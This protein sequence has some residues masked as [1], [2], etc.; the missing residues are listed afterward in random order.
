MKVSEPILIVSDSLESGEHESFYVAATREEAATALASGRYRAICL[1][2]RGLEDALADARWL[3]KRRNRVPVLALVDTDGVQKASRLFDCGVEEIVVRNA[4]LRENLIARVQSLDLRDRPEL[5]EKATGRLVARSPAMHAVLQ[6]VEKAARSRATVLI[7]GETGTG[8][9]IVARAIHDD[10]P[11]RKGPFVAINCAA[12]PETLL[13]SELFG[14]ERG[15]FTGASRSRAG[16]FE[17]ANGGTLFL[18]EIGETSPGFQ[19]KLL[20]ALQEGAVRRLGATHEIRVDVRIVAATNRELAKS[21]ELGE[22]RR[23]LF[24]RLNVFPISLPPLRARP[25]DVVPL[26]LRFL[27]ASTDDTALRDVSDDAA[28]LLQTY[29]WPGNVRELE[30]EVARL[31]AH[32]GAETELTARLLSPQIRDSSPGLPGGVGQESLR[33]TMARFEAWVLRRA[34]EHHGQR[35]IATARSLGI[36]RECLYKKLVRYGMQ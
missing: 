35:R 14:S 15:A 23:D 2:R 17:Q 6:L 19:V 26:V 1:D 31:V 30:N 16:H 3:R 32:S 7:Q 21:V 18:D 27:E 22:F 25:E 12:F 28:Q 36:T 9:E 29:P 11:R 34:L 24:Y 20:R 13:E 5:R 10:G 4:S 8:K 33:D